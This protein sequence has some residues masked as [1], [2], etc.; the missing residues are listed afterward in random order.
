MPK[1]DIYQN[2]S[3]VFEQLH[4][5]HAKYDESDDQFV[6]RSHMYSYLKMPMK[7]DTIK[8]NKWKI[9][10][11]IFVFSIMKYYCKIYYI[12]LDPWQM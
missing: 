11:N 7:I 12:L 1:L 3:K 5:K 4:Q 8:G 2:G 9:Q 10:W 6:Q